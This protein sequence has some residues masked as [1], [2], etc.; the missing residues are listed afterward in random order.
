MSAIRRHS[1]CCHSGISAETSAVSGVANGRRQRGHQND[2]LLDVS[3]ETSLLLGSLPSMRS[4]KLPSPRPIPAAELPRGTDH[5]CHPG[6]GHENAMVNRCGYLCVSGTS[7]HGPESDPAIGIAHR[8][9]IRANRGV[10]GKCPIDGF[11]RRGTPRVRDGHVVERSPGAVRRPGELIIL[12]TERVHGSTPREAE[13][14]QLMLK[15]LRLD[16]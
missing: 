7:A 14:F 4:E 1:R 8:R 2:P 16:A 3:A 15:S 5:C 11:G 6:H 12:S 13:K 10:F 9:A